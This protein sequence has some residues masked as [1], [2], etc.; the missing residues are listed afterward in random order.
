MNLSSL[1]PAEKRERKLKY[2]REYSRRKRGDE[3]WTAVHMPP[4]VIERMSRV[5]GHLHKLGQRAT[6]PAAMRYLL[7]LHDEAVS[8]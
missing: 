1:S 8:S 4:D 3:G 6:A 5:K 2:L 7:N